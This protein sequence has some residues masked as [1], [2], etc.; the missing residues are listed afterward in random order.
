MAGYVLDRAG[1]R[2][3]AVMIANHPNANAAQPAF[4]ALVEWLSRQDAPRERKES[5]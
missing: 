5:R 4:D 3:I 1:R 2:W